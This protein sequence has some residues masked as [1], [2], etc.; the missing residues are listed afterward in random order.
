MEVW[1]PS[2]VSAIR[3]SH[4]WISNYCFPRSNF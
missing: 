1:T 3:I 4:L 2:K